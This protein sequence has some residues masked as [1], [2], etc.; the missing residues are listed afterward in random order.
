MYLCG[1]IESV[2][3][4]AMASEQRKKSARQLVCMLCMAAAL[5]GCETPQVRPSEPQNRDTVMTKAHIR[6]YGQ[7][8]P[9]IHCNVLS[10]DMLSEGLAFDSLFH[11]TGSGTNLYLS[12]VFV[13]LS[14]SMLTSGI[15]TIDTTG[16]AMTI[17]PA[18]DCRPGLTGAYLL[19]IV[20]SSVRDT[21]LFTRGEMT[22]TQWADS[23]AME[24]E[25]YTESGTAYRGRTVDMAQ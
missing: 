18:V 23:I 25:F 4:Q 17:V 10:V 16:A 2:I 22:V 21:L 11:I 14:D 8:Y 15:Y 3:E 9:N 7:H 12:D 13:P 1:L 24:W 5:A 19:R 20:N 6:Y